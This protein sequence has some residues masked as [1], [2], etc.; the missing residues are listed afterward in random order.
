MNLT[1]FLIKASIQAFFS[2]VSQK[3][4]FVFTFFLPTMMGKR[5]LSELID[6][7]IC[8]GWPNIL[9]R[10]QWK[11]TGEFVTHSLLAT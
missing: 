5:P 7:T 10:M 9:V 1:I 4:Y 3:E 6:Q 11:I 2:N 8:R